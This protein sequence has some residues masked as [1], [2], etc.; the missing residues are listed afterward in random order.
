VVDD[1]G[2]D[3]PPGETGE[4]LLRN[5][6]IT[7][8]YYGM[9]EETAAAITADGWLH[10]GDLVI[11]DR[12]GTYTF[13]SRKKEVLRRRGENLSPAE[14]EEALTSH[15]SVLECAVIGV[16]SELTEEE[17]KAFIV[18]APGTTVDFAALRAHAAQLLA[19]YK[20]PRFWQLIDELPHTPTARVAK[21]RLPSGHT[22]TEW[23]AE[24]A[25]AGEGRPSRRG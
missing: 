25:N 10:T 16:P 12:D 17:I 11:V 20:V 5:P 23:D 24:A 1:E 19:P 9:P 7:P 2:R 22:E 6:V 3:L 15:P 18:P 13:V 21:H 4:L 14:V 8:G